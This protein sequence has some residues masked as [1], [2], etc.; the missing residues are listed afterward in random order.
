MNPESVDRGSNEG[1]LIRSR[2]EKSIG[3]LHTRLS[4][5]SGRE[6]TLTGAMICNLPVSKCFPAKTKG[7]TNQ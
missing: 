7:N 3:A 4:S 6:L 2:T 5:R 1:I